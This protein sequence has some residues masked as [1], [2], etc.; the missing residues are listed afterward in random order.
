MPLSNG[1]LYLFMSE[2][3]SVFKLLFSTRC[4]CHWLIID[5]CPPPGR[6]RKAA[7]WDFS[8]LE[9]YKASGVRDQHTGRK[10]PL[11]QDDFVHFFTHE[12]PRYQRFLFAFECGQF[13][14]IDS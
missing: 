10:R 14:D 3:E 7:T 12:C 4:D 9:K 2:S 5:R 13:N 1:F 6:G 11:C 8:R